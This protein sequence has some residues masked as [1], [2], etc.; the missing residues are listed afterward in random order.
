MG[1]LRQAVNLGAF[2]AGRVRPFAGPAKVTWEVTYRCNMRCNHCHLW[3]TKEHDEL[4]TDEAKRF[5]LDAKA[6][7]A[8]HISFSGGEPFLRHDI[9][10]LIAY[11]RDCGLSTAVNTN[12]SLI[13]TEERVAAV[14]NSGLGTAFISLDGADAATHNAVRGNDRAFDLALKAI[15]MLVSARKGKN[16]RVFIN[17]TITRGN[18]D[19][20]EEILSLAKAHGVDGM[21]MS[22]LQDIGKYSPDAGAGFAGMKIDQLSNRLRALAD[23]SDGLIPHTCEYLDN[24]RVYVESPNDLYRYRCVAGYATALIHPNGDV[25]PCPVA[26]E[27]MGS[28]RE[29]SFREVWFSE[30]ANEIRSRIKENKHPICWFDC[31]APVSVLL[32]DVRR[33]NLSAILDKKIIAHI[34]KKLAR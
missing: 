9:M 13:T 28:L 18:I 23:S 5:I 19:S 2:A 15:D 34:T 11:S 21:T 22:I 4:T 26:F 31:I 10:E 27:C 24:F 7:G 1:N 6:S 16:P 12:G 8:L 32:N 25:Y 30:K 33:L 3:Q 29:K 20:L 14:C 17:T